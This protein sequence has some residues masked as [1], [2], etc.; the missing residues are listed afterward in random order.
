MEICKYT[1]HNNSS[2]QQ[3]SY[4]ARS[5]DSANMS[6]GNSTIQGCKDQR[7]RDHLSNISKF[8]KNLQ[9]Q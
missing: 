5:S 3:A 4:S 1:T 8:N 2:T 7:G 9:L 6:R